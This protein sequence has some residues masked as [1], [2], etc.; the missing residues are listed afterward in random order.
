MIEV[1]RVVNVL[2]CY[3][4]HIK[5]R[6]IQAKTM[7]SDYFMTNPNLNKAINMLHCVVHVNC[8]DYCTYLSIC[9]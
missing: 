2:H 3:K 5:S 8:H 7:V 6:K 1:S 9:C 4:C